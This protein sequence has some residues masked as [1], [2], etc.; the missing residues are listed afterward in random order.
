MQLTEIRLMVDVNQIMHLKRYACKPK[1][2][3]RLIFTIFSIVLFLMQTRAMCVAH[4]HC[5]TLLATLQFAS[6]VVGRIA[7]AARL[8]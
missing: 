5:R 1:I 6:A 3:N 8:G 7:R 4:C 2:P